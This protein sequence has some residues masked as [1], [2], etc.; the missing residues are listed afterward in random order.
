MFEPLESYLRPTNWSDIE[1]A[2]V[3]T[4][5]IRLQHFLIRLN[6]RV[7]IGILCGS[8]SDADQ[9]QALK[10]K[11]SK[12]T[13]ALSKHCKR[14][15]SFAVDIYPEPLD[16]KALNAFYWLGGYAKAL[17]DE[18]KIPIRWGGDFNRNYVVTDEDFLDLVHFEI[19]EVYSVTAL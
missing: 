11:K 2:R 12:L 19:D 18:M 14:P 16:W 8:R 15:L 9:W 3:L 4:C 17:A 6:D 1:W 10:E 5:E 13:P 7:K